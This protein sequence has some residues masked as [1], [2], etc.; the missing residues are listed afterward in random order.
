MRQGGALWTERAGQ[1]FELLV[2]LARRPGEWVDDRELKDWFWGGA[3][4]DKSRTVF[5]SLIYNTRAIFKKHGIAGRIIEKEAAHR[6][7]TRLNLPP[8]HVQILG[9]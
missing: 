1:S 2:L 7:C 4:A 9:E 6:G 3:A 5:S 8:D